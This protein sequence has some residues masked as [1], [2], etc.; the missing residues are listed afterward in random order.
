MQFQADLLGVP[1][2]RPTVTE[3]TALGAAY[4]A[5]LAVGYW[6]GLDEIAA[7]WQVERVFEPAMGRDRVDAL[8]A[9]WARAVE[10]SKGWAQPGQGGE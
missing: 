9:G 8:C 6:S 4:L 10:R 2:L 5:G 7:Q 3:T 1:V